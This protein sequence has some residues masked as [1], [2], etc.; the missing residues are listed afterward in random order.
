MPDLNWNPQT[1]QYERTDKNGEPELPTLMEKITRYEAYQELKEYWQ[2]GITAINRIQEQYRSK[3]DAIM[4]KALERACDLLDRRLDEL[5][6]LDSKKF[7][8]RREINGIP[9][10]PEAIPL[11]EREEHER[12][13]RH[14]EEQREVKRPSVQ[15][16]ER[17]RKDPA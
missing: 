5:S 15:Y 6:E 12:Q 13:S 7:E 2:N 14:P 16:G 4:L 9:R 11:T 3:S 8:L 17:E 10:N 1:R